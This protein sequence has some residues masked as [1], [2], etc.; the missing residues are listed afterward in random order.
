MS[1]NKFTDSDALEKWKQ[2]TPTQDNNKP[3]G[4][5]WVNF[6]FARLGAIKDYM[7]PHEVT[8]IQN[9]L[10]GVVE[11]EPLYTLRQAVEKILA[12]EGLRVSIY[13]NKS[14][15]WGYADRSSTEEILERLK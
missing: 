4:D 9:F 2:D 5:E 1:G 7:R 12:C 10:D 11:N 6:A 8:I 3:V 14:Y 13:D 15:T